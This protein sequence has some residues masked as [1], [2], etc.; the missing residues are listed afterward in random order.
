[1][2]HI[3]TIL[4]EVRDPVAIAAACDRLGLQRPVHGTAELFSSRATGWQVQLPEWRY[5]LVCQIETGELH[6]D[7]FQGRWGAQV[8]LDAFLQRYAVEKTYLEAR[9]QGHSIVE[10]S[11][12][13]GSIKLTVQLGGQI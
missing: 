2:S 11:L 5:P 3:V 1:M 7:N 8:H 13:D 9:R 6:F 10:Q 12:S 4:T